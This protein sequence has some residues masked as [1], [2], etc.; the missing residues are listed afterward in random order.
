M[1]L[2]ALIEPI[3]EEHPSRSHLGSKRVVVVL[4]FTHASP[5]GKFF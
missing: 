5:V 4:A 3:I 2:I 1:N